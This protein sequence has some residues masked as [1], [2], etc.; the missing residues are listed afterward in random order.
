MYTL[1]LIFDLAFPFVALIALLNERRSHMQW[2]LEGSKV[3]KH[4]S[5]RSFQVKL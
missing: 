1:R 3:T 4:V 2:K 5:F